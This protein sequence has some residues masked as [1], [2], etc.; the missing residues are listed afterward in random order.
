MTPHPETVYICVKVIPNLVCSCLDAKKGTALTVKKW[1]TG[2]Y[3]LSNAKRLTITDI[4]NE[5]Y[6]IKQNGNINS[7]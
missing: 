2:N 7:Q 1:L 6:F 5:K 3:T 4:E